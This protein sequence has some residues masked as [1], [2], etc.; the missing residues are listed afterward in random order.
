MVHQVQFLNLA[1]SLGVDKEGDL[2][3]KNDKE[4]LNFSEKR[5]KIRLESILTENIRKSLQSC[6]VNENLEKLEGLSVCFRKNTIK[7]RILE[8][9]LYILRQLLAC[10]DGSKAFGYLLYD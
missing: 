9:L 8:G 5:S 6:K 3:L 4:R 7:T 1:A 2:T 10:Y